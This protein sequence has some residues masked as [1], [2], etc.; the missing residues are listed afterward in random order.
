M[1]VFRFIQVHNVMVSS[2]QMSHLSSHAFIFSSDYSMIVSERR[3][4]P[5]VIFRIPACWSYTVCWLCL[6]PGME[7]LP[8]VLAYAVFFGMLL[9]VFLEKSTSKYEKLALDFLH[10]RDDSLVAVFY[11]QHKW[12]F[13]LSC[14][15]KIPAGSP[16][17]IFNKMAKACRDL[18]SLI[19]FIHSPGLHVPCNVWH[20][21]NCSQ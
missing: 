12:H 3:R 2:W 18:Y 19:Y 17:F 21:W 8:G 13:C 15:P 11:Y 4:K 1:T 20:L 14:N 7:K 5:W 9:A 16:S 6:S 10:C